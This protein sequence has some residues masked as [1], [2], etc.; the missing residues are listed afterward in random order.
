[1]V[2]Y[3][4][5]TGLPPWYTTDRKK[6]FESLRNAPLTFPYHV[7]RTAQSI[8]KG[9]LTREPAERLGGTSG[10]EELKSHPF[11]AAIDWEAL[12]QR[13]LVPP[14]NPCSPS[15]EKES[16]ANFEREFTKM[17]TQSVDSLGGGT[18]SRGSRVG[19]DI[20]NGFTYEEKSVM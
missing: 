11:F 4:M 6:L 20:F 12:L 19:S 5:L 17:P 2:L 13:R 14:F 10:A 15:D 8:I 18:S 16:T 3:E 1:M 9:L 7:S